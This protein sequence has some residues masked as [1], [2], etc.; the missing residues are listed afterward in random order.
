ML[1]RGCVL[2]GAVALLTTALPQRSAAAND[3]VELTAIL[4]LTGSGAFLGKAEKDGIQMVVDLTNKAGGIGGRPVNVTFEDDTSSAQVAVTLANGVIAKKQQVF[5][6]PTLSAGCSAIAPLIVNGP[7]D[8]CFSAGMQ[9]E[10]GSYMYT[11]Q[12]SSADSLGVDMHY[13][14]DHGL[15]RIA[16]ITSTD[17]TGQVGE[18]GIDAVLKRPENNG[19]QIVIREHYNVNDLSVAAQISRIKNSNAQVL[20]AWGTGTPLGTV[21]RGIQDAGLDLPVTVSAGNFIY[22]EMKQFAGI[23]PKELIGAGPPNIAGDAL[24]NGPMKNAVHQYIE[25]FKAAGIRADISEANG[26]DPAQIVIGALKKLGPNATAAQ[27]RDYI[28]NLH[29]FAGA[30]GVYD[31]RSGDQRGI[32]AQ[33]NLVMV[34]WDVPKDTWVPISTFGGARR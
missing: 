26:W 20:I 34:R 6:G 14:R 28:N 3:P 21:F 10:R 30:N 13:F 22:P 24:P 2:L 16:L 19:L 12:V 29:G 25:A 9:P 27:I 4:S 1:R 7:V 17:Q 15:H 11:Y 5:F 23:L 32:N 33:Q 18:A 31:F 8:Y